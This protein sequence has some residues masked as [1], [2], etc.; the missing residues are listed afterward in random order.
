[1]WAFFRYAEHFAPGPA[2]RAARD[3]WFTAP[4]RM[5]ELPLPEGGE[6]F[7]VDAQGRTVRGHVWQAGI[8]SSRT[9]ETVYLVHGWG[10]RGAQFGAMVEPLVEAGHRVVVFDAPAHGDSDSGPSGPRRTNGVELA[11]ALDA[12]FCRFGPAEVVVAHSM[13]TIATYLAL[14]FGWL[15]A[16]RLVFIAPMVE[17]ESLFDQFQRA[18]GFGPRVR[19]AFDRAVDDYVGVPLTEFDARVQAAQVEPLPTL[20]ITDRDDRQT[21][22]A[23]VVDFAETIG[24][25]LVTTEGL[26]HRKILRDPAVI[27]RVVDFVSDHRELGET[28]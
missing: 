23:D 25:P 22:Y 21:P 20:V 2:G 28:A 11:K 4:P 27:A 12:V 17:A 13:G 18:L 26:G 15:G 14:R 9:P 19:R 6:A 7:E 8:E 3:L 16:D 5:G 1:M 24:A 10:G